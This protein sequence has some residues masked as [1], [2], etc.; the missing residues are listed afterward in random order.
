[1][2]VSLEK[3]NGIKGQSTGFT[4]NSLQQLFTLILPFELN[5]AG[6][7]GNFSQ[8]AL[9]FITL[10]LET[11]GVALAVGH[12]GVVVRLRGVVRQG[13][14][15]GHCRGWIPLDEPETKKIIRERR[16]SGRNHKG[17]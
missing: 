16:K 15:R 9:G 14:I 10:R 5:D 12:G 8:L 7:L 4:V 13:P 1:M 17:S 6:F 2:A 3:L 11:E